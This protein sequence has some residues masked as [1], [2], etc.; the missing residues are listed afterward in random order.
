M[1]EVDTRPAWLEERV[2][3]SLKVK[4]TLFKKLLETE[5]NN[6]ALLEF[7]NNTDA[8][9]VFFMEGPKELLCFYAPP[10]KA[11]KKCVY[12][13]KLRHAALTNENMDEVRPAGARD[14]RAVASALGRLVPAARPRPPRPRPLR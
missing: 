4:A 3:L 10:A 7:L 9:H 6:R 1:A 5:G 2:C 14:Q 13:V 8:G 12:F 11:T